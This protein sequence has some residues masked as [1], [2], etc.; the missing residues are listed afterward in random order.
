V[1]QTGRM[2]ARLLSEDPVLFLKHDTLCRCLEFCRVT[3]S[4]S[5]TVNINGDDA[6]SASL[7][8]ARTLVLLIFHYEYRMHTSLTS[9]SESSP[10]S[11]ARVRWLDARH[12]ILGRG[13]EPMVFRHGDRND[14]VRVG[15]SSPS[16]YRCVPLPLPPSLVHH[17]ANGWR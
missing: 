16:V 2:K 3:T 12:T 14:G 15:W 6:L 17:E 9:S 4:R 10:S 1:P 5:G 8:V 13:A 11:K 7:R